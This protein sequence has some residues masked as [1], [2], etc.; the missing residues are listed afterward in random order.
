MAGLQKKKSANWAISS[1]AGI[2]GGKGKV[3][4]GWIG[5]TLFDVDSQL[6]I[7]MGLHGAAVGLGLP[8]GVN[9]S[10]FSPTFFMTAEPLWAE[11]FEGLAL[12]AGADMTIGVGGCMAVVTFK[13]VDHNPYWLDIGGLQVGVSGGVSA[14]IYYVATS[15]KS[16]QEN[17]G[18]IISPSGDPLCGGSSSAGPN[19]SQGDRSIAP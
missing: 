13:G 12:V 6:F 15:I 7:P 18:C 9:I 14:G 10:T 17:N 3:G 11:D 16:A 5:L 1:G 4:V 2:G 8:V 19:S